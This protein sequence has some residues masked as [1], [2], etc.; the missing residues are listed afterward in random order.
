[1]LILIKDLGM[2]ETMNG[3]KRRFV[4]AQCTLCGKELEMRQDTFKKS[5]SC[6]CLRKI[7]APQNSKFK[8]THGLTDS[9]LYSK[10]KNMKDRCYNKKNKRYNRYGERG[11]SVCDKWKE[12][13]MSFYSWCIKHGYKEG[14]QLDRID[15]DGNYEPNNCRFVIPKKNARNRSSNVIVE[16]NAIKMTITEAAEKSGIDHKTLFNRFK[17]GDRGDVLFRDSNKRVRGLGAGNHKAKITEDEA[18]KIKILLN[19]G[20][21][22]TEI[23][24]I[25]GVS[26]YL[27][28]DIK[29]GKTW[30]HVR[31]DDTE[32]N[33]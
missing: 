29:R 14:L 17:R 6:G 28:S 26:K 33:E 8:E 1:M 11:I 7:T 13:F 15:N 21:K 31:I 25:F 5:K 27:I 3:T 22:Q 23:A 20:V 9:S 18:K 4:L 19:K 24:A 12:D 2:K 30:S 10:W 16:Y 32:V